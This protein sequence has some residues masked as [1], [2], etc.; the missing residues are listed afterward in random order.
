[1]NAAEKIAAELR[2]SKILANA[3]AVANANPPAAGA[4]RDAEKK[5]VAGIVERLRAWSDKPTLPLSKIVELTGLSRARIIYLIER[6]VFEQKDGEMVFAS[7]Q[8]H[9]AN[10]VSQLCQTS[11]SLKAVK[12]SNRK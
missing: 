1:M 12:E 7:V 10:R 8:Q 5:R 11:K 2:G 3:A 4:N 6:G 9:F